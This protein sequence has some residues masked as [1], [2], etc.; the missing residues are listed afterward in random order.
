MGLASMV[1]DP[2][3]FGSELILPQLHKLQGRDSTCDHPCETE[4][5]PKIHERVRPEG[6][7]DLAVLE[8]PADCIQCSKNHAGEYEIQ[9]I[10]YVI[11]NDAVS[12]C[13]VSSAPMPSCFRCCIPPAFHHPMLVEMQRQ[14]YQQSDRWENR[15]SGFPST[16]TQPRL[17]SR[18]PKAKTNP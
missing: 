4:H 18:K 16:F 12:S 6:I 13:C 11:C 1:T 7:S 2:S 5:S 15:C 14:V 17:R 10:L 8:H 3:G 9:P